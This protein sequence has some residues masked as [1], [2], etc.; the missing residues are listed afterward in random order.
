MLHRFV[1]WLHY[2]PELTRVAITAAI[3][4]VLAWI[5]Y[6]VVYALNGLAARA[7]TSWVIAFTI[8]I[9]RQHHLH[10]TLSFPATRL[11]YGDSLRREVLASIV[12]IVASAGL[13][14]ALTVLVGLHHRLAW[15][16]CL[17]SVATLEYALMKLFVFRGRRSEARQ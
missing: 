12:I 15:I 11:S 6:E 8:G 3:G 5:T 9:F 2:Q 17:V 1:K 14:Y 10:R 13:N 7:T 16:A 4:T